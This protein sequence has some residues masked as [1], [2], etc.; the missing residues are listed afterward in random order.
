MQRLQTPAGRPLDAASADLYTAMAALARLN[1]L[2]V[3][4]MLIA[5]NMLCSA[6]MFGL[7]IPFYKAGVIETLLASSFTLAQPARR[8]LALCY[9][10]ALIVPELGL[11]WAGIEQIGYSAVPPWNMMMG[12]G[13]CALLMNLLEA[14]RLARYRP[15]EVS[16]WR[17]M[18]P[19][20]RARLPFSLAIIVAGGAT[21]VMHT[22]WVDLAV[23]V[24]MAI[25]HI[26]THKL[27]DRVA[28][29]EVAETAPETDRTRDLVAD[30]PLLAILL[31]PA[32]QE[33]AKAYRCLQDQT[34]DAR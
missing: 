13:G 20:L 1:F 28:N 32:W 22:A 26:G 7:A 29:L 18:G 14:M 5:G 2:L 30:Y 31:T 21:A 25:W 10:I 33:A 23:G 15:R 3:G 12:V 19:T 27:L 9:S 24:V 6:S 16:L 8:R 11:I 17:A 4:M 34:G